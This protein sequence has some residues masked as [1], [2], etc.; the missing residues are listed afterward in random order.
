ML[1]RKKKISTPLFP[2]QTILASSTVG[3]QILEIN[4]HRLLNPFLY[5]NASLQEDQE[6]VNP[7]FQG[8]EF[9]MSHLDF[10]HSFYTSGRHL[11]LHTLFSLAFAYEAL[12]KLSFL[13][14]FSCCFNT[15]NS[16]GSVLALVS[17]LLPC[18]FIGA[19]SLTSQ[20]VFSHESIRKIKWDNT[21]KTSYI[22]AKPKIVIH[23]YS[24]HG[25]IYNY[26][27]KKLRSQ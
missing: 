9:L 20:S 3:C 24:G 15:G 11:F 16:C 5:L 27:L 26:T 23:E 19:S 22:V 10:T 21:G 8:L 18:P 6:S 4:V 17:S 12:F 2:V 7:Q 1:K 25:D 13:P 14:S